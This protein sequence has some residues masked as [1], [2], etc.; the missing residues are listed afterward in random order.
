MAV[1]ERIES[2]WARHAGAPAE[3]YADVVGAVAD[4]DPGELPMVAGLLFHVGAEHLGRFDDVYTALLPLAGRCEDPAGNAS[5]Q[6]SLAAAR[7]CLGDEAGASRHEEAAGGD[8]RVTKGMVRALAASALVGQRKVGEAGRLFDEALALASE[9]EGLAR[10]IAITGNNV[11]AGLEEVAGRTPAESD[12]MLRAAEAAR[13][14][15]EIAGTWINVERAEYRLAMTRLAR[16][17][18]DAALVHASKVVEITGQHGSEAGEMFFGHE[19]LARA[20]AARGDRDLAKAHRDE[21]AGWLAQV[22]HEGFAAFCAESLQKLDS[23]L[24]K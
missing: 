5:L 17:E 4:A 8:P 14:Y 9:S 10:S 18:P 6:R 23:A 2:G 12:L 22:K 21:C 3:V 19:A 7:L 11:A 13:K 15:W 1:R 16:G 24:S 20:Y